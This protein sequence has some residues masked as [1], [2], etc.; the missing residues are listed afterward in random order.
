MLRAP[1]PL[2]V[3]QTSVCAALTCVVTFLVVPQTQPPALHG[4]PDDR[5][6]RAGGQPR[7]IGMVLRDDAAV[8]A[9]TLR[10]MGAGRAGD[11]PLV[12]RASDTLVDGRAPRPGLV[13]VDD[14]EGMHLKAGAALAGLHRRAAVRPSPL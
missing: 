2:G 11:G 10:R 1:I 12:L 14:R 9:V 4:H 13:L 8:V 7:A 6:E 5:H 3:A